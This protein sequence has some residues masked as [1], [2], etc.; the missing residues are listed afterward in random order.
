MD[1]TDVRAVPEIVVMHWGNYMRVVCSFLVV[2]LNIGVLK[3][4]R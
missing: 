1:W 3:L 4:F 2:N